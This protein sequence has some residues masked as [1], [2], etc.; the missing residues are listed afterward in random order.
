MPVILW[1]SHARQRQEEWRIKTGIT[2]EE[3]EELVSHPRQIVEGDGEILI[4]QARRGDG[5][6]RAAFRYSA[7]NKVI[8]TVYWT[9]KTAKYWRNS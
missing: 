4:A 2:K 3:I 7:E 5:L 9:S 6:L 8:I 1:T